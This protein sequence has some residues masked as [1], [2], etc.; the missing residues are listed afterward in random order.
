MF[1]TSV[2]VSILCAQAVQVGM[3][4]VRDR[5]GCLSL[6]YNITR[7]CRDLSSKWG[8]TLPPNTSMT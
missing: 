6:G 8:A 3:D 5:W 2:L 1:P 4:W 7:L